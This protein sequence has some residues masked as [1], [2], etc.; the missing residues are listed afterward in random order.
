MLSSYY[1]L[2]ACFAIHTVYIYIY[3][4]TYIK[5]YDIMLIKRT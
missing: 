4:D 2:Y 5:H 1:V 3:T